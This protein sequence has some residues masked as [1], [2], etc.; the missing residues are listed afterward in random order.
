MKTLIALF[1]LISL[2]GADDN[3]ALA[4]AQKAYWHTL[5][6]AQSNHGE[7]LRLQLEAEHLL[8]QL[9]ALKAAI[10]Q[11]CGGGFTVDDNGECVAGQIKPQEVE[12]HVTR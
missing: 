3:A 9:P 1:V 5:A 10:A 12:P 2:A 11:A 6:L 4:N 8:Q 7:S